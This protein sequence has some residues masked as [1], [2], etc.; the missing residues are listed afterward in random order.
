MEAE[1]SKSFWTKVWEFILS[2]GGI[3]GILSLLKV[4]ITQIL[5]YAIVGGGIVLITINHIIIFFQKMDENI[6]EIKGKL[7]GGESG[8]KETR[9]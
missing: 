3:L 2:A 8:E 7:N 6:R 4:E 5:V 9:N 1:S